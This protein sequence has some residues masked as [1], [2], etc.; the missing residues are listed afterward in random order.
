MD[1]R[2]MMGLAAVAAG[3]VL[4]YLRRKAASADAASAA[5]VMTSN[6]AA[7]NAALGHAGS[8]GQGTGP[9]VAFLPPGE[10]GFTPADQTASSPAPSQQPA[11][12]H[13]ALTA[14]FGAGQDPR[15]S[16]LKKVWELDP[17]SNGYMSKEDYDRQQAFLKTAW[18]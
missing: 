7:I 18:F 4:L 12:T 1:R 10:T 14:T 3:V 2:A 8:T 16:D 17:A 6:A 9:A 15:V 5:G 11:T 13:P